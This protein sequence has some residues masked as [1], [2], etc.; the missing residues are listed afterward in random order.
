MRVLS[1]VLDSG[2]GVAFVT[3]ILYRINSSEF[4]FTILL[5]TLMMAV[6]SSQRVKTHIAVESGPIHKV[7]YSGV[8]S[9]SHAIDKLYHDGSR[10]QIIH[11]TRRHPG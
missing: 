3:C 4:D 7:A 5:L 6:L 1:Y 2:S 9:A 10:R 11:Q 8:P